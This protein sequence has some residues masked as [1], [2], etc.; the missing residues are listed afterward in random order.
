[1]YILTT[2]RQ[3]KYLCEASKLLAS[4]DDWYTIDVSIQRA[5]MDIIQ[6]AK[7][8]GILDKVKAFARRNGGDD[9]ATV[10]T[11]LMD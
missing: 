8:A 11:L 3:L 4:S 6:R 7:A 1:M 2:Y 5:Q 9:V 10:I